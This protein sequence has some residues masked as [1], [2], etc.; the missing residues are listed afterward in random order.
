MFIASVT[1]A[2]KEVFWN[3][4]SGARVVKVVILKRKC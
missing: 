1:F 3:C 4:G 2:V